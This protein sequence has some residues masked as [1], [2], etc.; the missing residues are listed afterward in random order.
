MLR[1]VTITMAD[2]GSIALY[3]LEPIERFRDQSNLGAQG[4][5]PANGADR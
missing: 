3:P 5:R 1:S 2:D 4:R